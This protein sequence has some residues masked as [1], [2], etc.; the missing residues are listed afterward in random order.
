VWLACVQHNAAHVLAVAG[1]PSL[2]WFRLDLRLRDN[3]ALNA[4]LARGAPVIPVYVADDAAE[5]SKPLGAAACWWLHH[6]LAALD[7]SLRERGLRLTLARG[8]AAAVLRQL[9]DETGAAAVYWSHRYEPAAREQERRVA[10]T[11]REGGIEA[12]GFGSTLLFEPE[13]IANKQGGPY[14]VFTPFWRHCLAQPIPQPV[15]LAKG[16]IPSPKR[17][18]ASLA[19]EQLDLLP[20]KNW[21]AGLANAWKPGE[22]HARLRLKTF[23]SERVAE[24][25]EQRDSPGA[26]GTSRLSPH[27][28]FGE[29]GPRQIWAAANALSAES[30]VFPANAGVQRFLTELGWR[31]F[32]YHLLVHF[33]KT[34][35]MPLRPEFERFPWAADPGGRMLETWQQGRTGYPIVDAGM[36]QLWQTGWMHNRVRMVA[37]SFLVKHLRLPWTAGAAWFWDTLVDADLANNT[38]GWQ[39]S[40]GCGADAAP[41]FRIFAP[42]LQGQKFDPKGEYVRRWVPE[43]AALPDRFLHQPWQAPEEVRARAEVRLGETYPEPIVDHVRARK[44]ALAAFETLRAR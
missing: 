5:G 42:V 11:L 18:P 32:A 19:L 12:R 24:Y 41:Y 28:R 16:T 31:E 23:F 4:A 9:A 30:G 8:D 17:W 1:T 38:L 43:I 29:I 39:W 21:D 40:A 37:A 26:D 27:L 20:H 35:E 13:E 7:A 22:A 15:S 25:D 33:P 36:R 34:P 14:K 2:L 44:A 3:P 6:S 10:E